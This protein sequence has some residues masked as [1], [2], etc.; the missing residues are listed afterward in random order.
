MKKSLLSFF[1]IFLMSFL[2]LNVT[3]LEA[4]CECTPPLQGPPGLPGSPGPEGPAGP[5]GA[6]NASAYISIDSHDNQI[7]NPL[8]AVIFTDMQAAL[9]MSFSGPS[10][11]I[12][13][14]ENGL[15]LVTYGAFVVNGDDA[16]SLAFTV[17][18]TPDPRFYLIVLND[19]IEARTFL[20]HLEEGDVITITNPRSIVS[21][22][23][24]EIDP[25]FPPTPTASAY[26]TMV[27]IHE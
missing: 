7:L 23:K 13:V 14:Q 3:S 8:D 21:A 10:T 12:T 25:W 4:R 24:T 20:V 22:K 5:A 2:C 18:G 19:H 27:K 11:T 15:Y 6:M 17:N 1:L 9:N 26:L 16:E